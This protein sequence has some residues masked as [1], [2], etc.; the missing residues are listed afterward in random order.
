M[1]FKEYLYSLMGR[2]RANQLLDAIKQG[3]TIIV[4]GPQGP[5]GKTTLAKIL[6]KKGVPAIECHKTHI[7]VL[8]EPLKK[9]TPNFEN[10]VNV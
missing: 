3:K 4:A 6:K 10:E 8:Q 5:S 7:I 9:M 1:D 2:Q